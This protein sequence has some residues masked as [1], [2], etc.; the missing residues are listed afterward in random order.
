[1]HCLVPIHV[2]R[3]SAFHYSL[4]VPYLPPHCPPGTYFYWIVNVVAMLFLMNV[5]LSIVIDGY[6]GRH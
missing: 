4:F 5:L 6:E 1:M 2:S 3:F